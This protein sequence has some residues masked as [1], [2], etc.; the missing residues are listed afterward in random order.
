MFDD[1][2]GNSVSAAWGCRALGSPHLARLLVRDR[3]RRRGDAP[4]WLRSP[5]DSV[6]RSW[7]ASDVLHDRDGALANKCDGHRVGAHFAAHDAAGGVRRRAARGAATLFRDATLTGGFGLPAHLSAA[8]TIKHFDQEEEP[9][10]GVLVTVLK[11]AP[12]DFRAR[13]CTNRLG[14]GD[15]RRADT[16]RRNHSGGDEQ[17]AHGGDHSEAEEP[18]LCHSTDPSV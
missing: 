16:A 17:Y 18:R 14:V 8:P 12:L 13:A 15:G 2:R 5:T 4:T 7:L 6:R 10:G 9:D 11:D 3:P 1:R